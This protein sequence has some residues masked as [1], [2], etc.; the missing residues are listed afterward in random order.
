MAAQFIK[1]ASVK[2]NDTTQISLSKVIEDGEAK[3]LY[4][5]NYIT[6]PRYT[7]PTKGTMV[8]A[9]QLPEFLEAVKLAMAA[10]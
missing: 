5:N 10:R 6:S 2:V 1:V 3:G 8:P 4:I 7:G 9:L